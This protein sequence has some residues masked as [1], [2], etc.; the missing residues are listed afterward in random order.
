VAAGIVIE[1]VGQR[2]LP[3]DQHQPAP[4][5]FTGHPVDW[6]RREPA[7]VAMRSRA[8]STD[9]QREHRPIACAGLQV[10]A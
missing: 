7:V 6:R 8:L 1:V 2:P 3:D 5:D 9:R 4:V 10:E